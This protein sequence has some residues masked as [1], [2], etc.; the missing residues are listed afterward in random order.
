MGASAPGSGSDGFKEINVTPMV[1]VML[2]LLVVFMAT[3]PLIST[4]LDVELPVVDAPAEAITEP[5]AVL[6]VTKDERIYLGDRELT[7]PLEPVLAADPKLQARRELYIQADHHAP[8][9]AVARVL[10]AARAAGIVGLNLLVDSESSP[11]DPERGHTA[12]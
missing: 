5:P 3:A 10:S 1:D 12:R 2:V 9:G 8:Y 6:T 11:G 4:G 7:G